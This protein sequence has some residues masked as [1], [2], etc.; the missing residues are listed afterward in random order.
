MERNIKSLTSYSIA[1]TDGTIGEVDEFYFDDQSYKTRY[2]IVKTG[3]WLSG[4]SVLISPDAVSKQ[5]WKNSIFPVNIT[6]EQVKNSP[7][8]DTDKPVSR[9]QEIDLYGHYQ[10]QNY[11]GSGLY[12]GSSM[13][14]G[15]GIGMPLPVVDEKVLTE[16]D[17]KDKH[18]DDD[19]HLRSTATI[20]GYHIHATDGEIG[21]VNDFIIDD[22]T[23]QL[24][25]V[26]V[27]TANWFGGKK[28][29]IPI[30]NIE[31][32]E[33]ASDL[34]YLAIDKAA[35]DHSPLFDEE[36]YLHV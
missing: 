27:D 6:K 19:I 23:W 21:H 2:L 26:V 31:R 20:T 28:V 13:G 5:P 12:A 24:T 25:F 11:W 34:L 18:S 32:I 1:A 15:M 30:A 33:W 7:D 9:Q 3:S 36:A 14:L 29:L 10:W 35:V 8:I 16:A 22:Q 17:K 4:R